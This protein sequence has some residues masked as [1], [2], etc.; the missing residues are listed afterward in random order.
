MAGLIQDNRQE[1]LTPDKVNAQIK[2]PPE[3]QEAYDRV[4]VAGMK[5]MF[6]KETNAKVL[7]AI[8]GEGPISKRLGVGIA[9]LIA[10]LFKQS[11]NTIPPQVIIPAGTNLLIQAADFL[12]R[13]GTEQITNEDIGEA[14]QVMMNTVLDMF[15]ADPQKVVGALDQFDKSRS[16][17]AAQQMGA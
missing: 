4:V 17:Q 1:E 15:G 16:Q 11:N 7:K 12:K 3:L 9:G 2:M 5:V 13:S 6:S 10:T 8:E 14:L